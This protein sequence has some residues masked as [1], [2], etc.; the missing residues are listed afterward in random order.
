M[1]L[2]AFSV[3]RMNHWITLPDGTKWATCFLLANW[4]VEG[5]DTSIRKNVTSFAITG[6]SHDSQTQARHESF[7][8]EL[9]Y[10]FLEERI[11]EEFKILISQ[12]FE[13]ISNETLNM[14]GL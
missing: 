12:T 10:H 1:P 5:I 7:E 9:A 8:W 13:S 11:P 4:D 6:C 3:L 14:I 2:F